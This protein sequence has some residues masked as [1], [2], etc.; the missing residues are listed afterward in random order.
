M[1]EGVYCYLV[2]NFMNPSVILIIPW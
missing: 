1:T 2:L